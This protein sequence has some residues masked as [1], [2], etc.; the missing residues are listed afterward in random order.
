MTWIGA[1]AASGTVYQGL[2]PL[3]VSWVT[4]SEKSI[5]SV[6]GAA[7]SAWWVDTE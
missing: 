5:R 3:I 7:S 1:P 2:A 6:S 4:S